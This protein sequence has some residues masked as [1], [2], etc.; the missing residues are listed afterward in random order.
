MDS[1]LRYTIIPHSISEH[2]FSV[3]IEIP[4]LDCDVVSLSLPAWIPG[5][6]MIRDFAQHIHSICAFDSDNQALKLKPVD[7]QSWEVTTNKQAC[8]IN[9]QVFAFDLSVRGAYLFDEYA[10]FNG[11]S[12]FLQVDTLEDQ[13][14]EV[15]IVNKQFD[16]GWRI[17]SALRPHTNIELSEMC[18]TLLELEDLAPCNTYQCNDYQELIDH[19]VLM[20]QFE[21]ASFKVKDTLFHLVLS[22]KNE[23][24]IEQICKDLAPICEHHIEMFGGF[25]E[26]EYWFI[27]L[28][29]VDGFGG[30]E[31]R[32]S[33]ALMYPRFHLPMKN[34]FTD[35]NTIID[36]NYQ[37]FLSLC[38][39]ELFH[40]W[41][42]KRS[43]PEVMIAPQL[44]KESYMEQLWIYEG[45]TSFFDDLSLAKTKLVSL[46]SYLE[47][48]AQNITRL[49]RTQGRHKQSV[50]DSSFY[51]WTKFY[52]Q[53]AN[54]HN[55]I[56]SY[57]NKG[58]IIALCLDLTIRQLSKARY[59]LRDLT[60][61]MWHEYGSKNIGTHDSVVQDLCKEHFNIDVGPF[62][63]IALY[64]TIDLPLSQLLSSIGVDLHFRAR[65][66][67]KDAGGKPSDTAVKHGFGANYKNHGSGVLIQSI[68]DGSPASR[69]GLQVGDLI[70]SIAD[71][72]VNEDNLQALIDA[73]SNDTCQVIALRQGRVYSSELTIENAILDTVYL[74]VSNDEHFAQW[75]NS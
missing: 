43:K 23:T 10:F 7:K 36:A 30:L 35:T 22:G 13:P 2:L 54:S 12:T 41:H 70:I 11:T 48:L 47:L 69:A 60:A 46:E 74:T 8:Y 65:E 33:T 28:L 15:T 20:G 14:C 49:I 45:F 37:R 32:A 61:L 52:K 6:Y 67:L 27:T 75:L 16:K 24:D 18:K 55:H 73:Q 17:A 9:Y 3:V 21:K 26:A 34:K 5:S 58:A 31:H 72:Q 50:T 57:Y 64:S 68:Q 56:V 62:L 53:D 59:S 4:Q 42:I 38:S 44:D 25:P 51:A 19:P 29:T 1:T 39:H 40:T 71:W 63:E 66:K